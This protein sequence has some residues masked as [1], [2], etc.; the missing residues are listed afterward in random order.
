M[1]KINLAILFSTL[2]A[3]SLVLSGCLISLVPLPPPPPPVNVSGGWSGVYAFSTNNQIVNFTMNLT[4]DGTSITGIFSTLTPQYLQSPVT[5]S[6][7]GYKINLI[8]S[9][10]KEEYFSFTG[11]VYGSNWGMSGDFSCY[12]NGIQA[13]SGAWSAEK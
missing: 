3:L 10:S 6:V 13:F 1:K 4:Q 7:N 12:Y 2:L 5:G 9:V 8:V 11:S